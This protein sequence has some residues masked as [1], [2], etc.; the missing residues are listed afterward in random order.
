MWDLHEHGRIRTRDGVPTRR[1]RKAAEKRAKD[2]AAAKAAE[3]KRRAAEKEAADKKA[4]EAAQKLAK[5]REDAF[6]EVWKHALRLAAALGETTVTEAVWRRAHIDIEGTDPGESAETIRARN[7]AAKRVELARTNGS[8]NTV[9][10]TT[11]A[12]RAIQVKA[13]RRTS[14]Y[15][16]VPP[17]RKKN[18]TPK[19]HPVA[20]AL[21]ADAKRDANTAKNSRPNDN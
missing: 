18:D 2:E 4:A 13:P 19:F 7:V 5:D 6:P 8:L 14:S 10:K 17:R 1:E 12:Q 3:E 9:S 20:R 16:P 11:N 21:A 15:T